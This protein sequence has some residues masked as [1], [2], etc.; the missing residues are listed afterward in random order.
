LRND[1]PAKA[2]R[3]FDRDRDGGVAAEAAAILVIENLEHAL[4]RG[5][6]VYAEIVS[7]G[8]SADSPASREG[9]GMGRAMRTAMT[10]AGCSPQEIDCISAHAPGDPHMDRIEVDLIKQVFGDHAYRIPVSSLKGNTG[11]PM[12]V[13]GALQVI[14][15]ALNL[16][17][18]IVPPTAN[19][20]TPDP[21]CDLDH[22]PIRARQLHLG[23]AM[24]NT[25]GFGRG[26]S[27][28][29]L[30]AWHG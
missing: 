29:I 4:A 14:G 5:A 12:A 26:N 10:N 7:Y 18:Q 30:D 21:Q 15:S 24:V 16:H 8:S 1:A 28:L 2:C 6:P 17:H 19:L 27:C 11:N 22:V 25:H 9:D 3:P 20:E 23:R 13:G